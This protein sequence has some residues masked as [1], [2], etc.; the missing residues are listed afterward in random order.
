MKVLVGAI[1]FAICATAFLFFA[2]KARNASYGAVD[3]RG[4]GVTQNLIPF[5][6]FDG[7]LAVRRDGKRVAFLS[8]EGKSVEFLTPEQKDLA[9]ADLEE[10]LAATDYPFAIHRVS[11]PIDPSEELSRVKALIVDAREKEQHAAEEAK[12]ARERLGRKASHAY[13]MRSREAEMRRALLEEVY[14]PRAQVNPEAFE[15]E[16]YVT[17]VFPEG[18]MVQLEAKKAIASFEQRFAEAGYTVHVMSPTKIIWALA[19]YYGRYPSVA[20]AREAEQAGIAGE[21]THDA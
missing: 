11:K 5:A 17:L 6:C 8:V 12:D 2:S 14:L 3:K 7:P 18:K 1:L 9:A 10:A 4:V 15:I 13:Q 21:E 20:E 19:N 16:T